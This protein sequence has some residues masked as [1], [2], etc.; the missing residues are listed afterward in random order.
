MNNQDFESRLSRQPWRT[1]PAAWRED[2]LAKAHAA[3]PTRCPPT[4]SHRPAWLEMLY[5]LLWPSPRAWAGVAALWLIALA[6]NLTISHSFSSPSSATP[7]MVVGNP[8]ESLRQRQR[9]MAEWMDP[10]EPPSAQP[11]REPR[12][13]GQLRPNQGMG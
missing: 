5:F 6:G 2:I 7:S 4:A 3:V 12:P 9:V 10:F 11:S 1:L 8:V 13:R